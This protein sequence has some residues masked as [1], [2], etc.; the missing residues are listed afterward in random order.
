LV[1]LKQL[2]PEA[3][4]TVWHHRPVS[5]G[6]AAITGADKA[7]FG[8]GDAL[9]SRPEIAVI[10]GPSSAHVEVALQLAAHDVHLLIEKPLSNRL[11]GVQLLLDRC[12]ERRLALLVGYNFRFYDPLRLLRQTIQEGRIGRVL[13]VRAEVGQ[14]LP[15]WRTGID[16]RYSVSARFELGGGALLELSHEIDYVRWLI[17]EVSEVSA[18][19][20]RV[21]DLDIDVEDTAEI[22]FTFESGAIGSIHLDM[23][24]RAP[25]RSCRVAGSEGT[26]VWDFLTNEVRHY[27]SQSASWTD[28][29]TAHCRDRNE[30][31]IA[32]L[33]HFL[34]CVRGAAA[35]L[36]TGEDGLR[37]LQLVMAARKSSAEGR[38]VDV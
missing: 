15:D 38:V 9:D 24:Q 4:V 31:Y 34:E 3:C 2:E 36:V 25:T 11:E 13:G 21:G 1:N 27:S 17:G 33:A 14:Y 22:T 10:A 30:M 35:P 23:V 26:L 8:L 19:V 29:C 5:S 32:E 16:Y 7:V 37:V 20:G 12:H 18:K 28:I 6:S